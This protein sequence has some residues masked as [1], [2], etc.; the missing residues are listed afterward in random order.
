MPLCGF[1]KRRFARRALAQA[2]APAVVEV[3]GPGNESRPFLGP[4]AATREL[5]RSKRVRE[6]MIYEKLLTSPFL[7]R[8]KDT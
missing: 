3:R 4:V 1:T 5:R 8:A 7:L 2:A 6:T